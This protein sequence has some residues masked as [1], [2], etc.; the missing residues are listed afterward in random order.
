MELIVT[1]GEKLSLIIREEINRALNLKPEPKQLPD[2]C[3]FNEALEI[4]GLSK[5]K[6]YKLTALNQIPFRKFNKKL[7]FSR[8]E[9]LTWMDA[10]TLE[11]KDHR[12]EATLY[13]AKSA[14]RK[15]KE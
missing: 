5:S 12:V 13:L 14:K 2:R 4:T 15:R 7:V 10:Q 11:P 9:L 1:T 3:T 8:R 6:L